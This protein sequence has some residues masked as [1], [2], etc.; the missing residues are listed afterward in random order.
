MQK[1]LRRGGCKNAEQCPRKYKRE[2]WGSHKLVCKKVE[3][4]KA[5]IEVVSEFDV[6]SSDLVRKRV[7]QFQCFHRDRYW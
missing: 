6:W 5:G 3:I 7:R 1:L 4:P 2:D